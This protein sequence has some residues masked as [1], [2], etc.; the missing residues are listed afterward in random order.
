M[1]TWVF[2]ALIL[3]ISTGALVFRLPGLS[4]RPMHTDEAVHAVKFNILWE[5]GQY[6]YD[7]QEYHGPTLYYFALPVVW[8]SGA[9]DFAETSAATFR[10]VP[11]LFGVGLIVLLMLFSDGLGR[12][13]AICAGVLTAISPAMVYYSR[14]YIQ[15][16]LLVFFTLVA[17]VAGWRYVR[18]RRVGWA[19]LAGVAVGLMHATKETCIVA[20]GALLAALVITAAWTRWQRGVVRAACPLVPSPDDAGKTHRQQAASGTLRVSVL[21]GGV[22]VAVVVSVLFF[23]A[24][25]TN[26][27]GPLDSLRAY[28]TYFDRAG[29]H[30]LHDHP[31]HYY[32]HMLIYTHYKTGPVWSEALILLL[33]AIGMVAALTG[34][35]IRDAHLP[36]IRLLTIYTLLMAV[37]YSAIPYKTPWSMLSFLHGMILLAGVGATALVVW[38]RFAGLRV[39]VGL[40]LAAGAAQLGWQAHLANSP[41]W[42]ADNR[43]PYAYAHPLAGVERL[44][45]WVERVAAFHPAREGMLIKVIAPDPWPLP[46][47]LRRFERVGYWEQ[48]PEDADAPVVIS[49]TE[50]EPPLDA[51]LRGEY[52]VSHYGLRPDVVLLVYVEEELWQ[53][54]ARSFA[55]PIPVPS[56]QEGE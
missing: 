17:I 25:F 31:W 23:S 8:L 46:W 11:V 13:S 6:R 50:L 47:Y 12:T 5:E 29:G 4:R 16:T 55:D 28:A 49:S 40:L 41:R 14:Y 48:P 19:L 7:P 27:A 43:N 34:K 45:D 56:S 35:G 39:V 33:A 26:P 20:W 38:V 2:A 44:T 18:S 32:L 10:L 53:R 15:E 52:R 42:H 51:W 3:I 36:L 37:I 1:K 24:F 30:G 21:G 54:F 22:A 9:R